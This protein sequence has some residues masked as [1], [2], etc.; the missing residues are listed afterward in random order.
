[1]L[2]RSVP[3]QLRSLERTQGIELVLRVAAGGVVTGVA[4][5]SWC[6]WAGESRDGRS[7]M[8]IL[9][10][11]GAPWIL[12]AFAIGAVV[13]A[14]LRVSR[15]VAAAAGGVAG[16]A[17]LIVATYVYYG[18]A[19]TGGLGVGGAELATVGWTVGSVV[20]GGISGALAAVWLTSPRS[21]LATL[22]AAGVGTAVASEAAF[23]LRIG[24]AGDEAVIFCVLVSQVA[25][26]LATPFALLRDRRALPMTFVIALTCVP[27]SLIAGQVNGTVFDTGLQVSRGLRSFFL[28]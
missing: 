20:V 2:G 12:A 5:G 11:L 10:E 1:M 21:R 16:A 6:R 8:G 24:S 22:A 13:V 15:G 23:H 14:G 26:G 3:D 18:P 25:I 27:A 9:S 7:V 28:G 19:R 17:A 4:L